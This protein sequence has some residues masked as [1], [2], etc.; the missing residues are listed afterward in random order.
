[1]RLST[2]M[3]LVRNKRSNWG[4]SDKTLLQRWRDK[5]KTDEAS[6]RSAARERARPKQSTVP[7]QALLSKETLRS[8]QVIVQT[9]NGFPNSPTA[10]MLREACQALNE[11]G[12]QA[13]EALKAFE[14]SPAARLL[15][16]MH[17]TTR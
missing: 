12:S 7:I 14:N 17:K 8:I 10:K 2:A 5:W 9:I 3:N 6:F 15:R 4:A 1:M 11:F 13:T 16:D